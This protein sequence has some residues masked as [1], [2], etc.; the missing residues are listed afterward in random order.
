MIRWSYDQ[1]QRK[2]NDNLDLLIESD[3]EEE[4]EDVDEN[5]YVNIAQIK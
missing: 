5:K 2:E 3:D 1:T 4:F